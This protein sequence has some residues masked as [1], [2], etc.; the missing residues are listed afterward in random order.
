MSDL[1]RRTSQS[2]CSVADDG[3]LAAASGI[4]ATPEWTSLDEIL[5]RGWL[6]VW[7]QPKIDLKQK[8]LC[9]AEA[10][11]RARHPERGV[12]QPGVFLPNATEDAMLRLSE[13]VIL[14][15]LHDWD[16]FA[17]HGFPLKLA[18]NVP[19]ASLFRLPLSDIV[20]ENRPKS[21]KWPGLILEVKEGQIV[22]DIQLAHQVATQLKMYGIELSIDDFGT[23]YSHLARL[24]DLPFGEL[25]LDRNMVMNCGEDATSAALC[26]TAIELAHRFGSKAV[27]EGIENTSGLETLYKM[28]CDIAQGFLLARPMTRD[29]LLSLLKSR[30]T[31]RPV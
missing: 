1:N 12:I 21:D 26:Q 18:V 31:S 20:C 16:C 14:K 3:P 2:C 25:K 22:R 4:A 30:G 8:F 17:V 9:G 28:G 5:D 7:Y 24:R 15:A 19:A 11:S 13:K 6:E 29:R 27:A 23:G 10:L